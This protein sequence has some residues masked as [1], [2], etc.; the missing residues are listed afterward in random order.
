LASFGLALPYSI[1]SLARL[2]RRIGADHQQ[3]RELGEQRDRHEVFL[4]R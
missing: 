1:S 4:R 3:Q 2:D